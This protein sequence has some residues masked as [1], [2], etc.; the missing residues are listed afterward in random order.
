ME[1]TKLVYGFDVPRKW[2]LTDGE[3]VVEEAWLYDWEAAEKSKG[4][5]NTDEKLYWNLEEVH[6]VRFT[7]KQIGFLK[8]LIKELGIEHWKDNCQDL[9]FAIE[10]VETAEKFTLD[11]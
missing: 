4:I 10:I 3:R 1:Q 2:V 5:E 8:H 7:K 6:P 11:R 9:L